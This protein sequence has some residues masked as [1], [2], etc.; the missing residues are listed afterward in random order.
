[1]ASTHVSTIETTMKS[2]SP[3]ESN[4]EEGEE[5]S[6]GFVLSRCQGGQ[7]VYLLVKHSDGGHWAFPKGHI[8]AGEDELAAARREIAEET[9]IDGLD[10]VAGFR[11]ISRYCYARD[12]RSISKTVTY[13]LAETETKCVCLSNEHTDAVWLAQEDARC[14]LSH[15]DSWRIL[16]EAETFLERSDRKG[17]SGAS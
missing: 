15:A 14:R 3:N 16:D 13:F 9:G 12:G 10:P 5:R 4:A 6:A 17:H 7:R 8:E 2:T 11:A 1:L